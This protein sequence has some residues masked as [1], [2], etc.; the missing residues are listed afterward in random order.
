MLQG[1][2]EVAVSMLHGLRQIIAH[3]TQLS[4]YAENDFEKL[5]TQPAPSLLVLTPQPLPRGSALNHTQAPAN[6][7]GMLYKPLCTPC[8]SLVQES[9]THSYPATAQHPAAAVM[10]LTP[11]HTAARHKGTALP[12]GKKEACS[13]NSPVLQTEALALC[14]GGS[15]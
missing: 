3:N 10:Q 5:T 13:R 15:N 9:T 2:C 7:W 1:T 12:T 14:T 6:S 4:Q 8:S 11:C